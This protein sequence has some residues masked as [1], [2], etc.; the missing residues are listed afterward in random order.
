MKI[1]EINNEGVPRERNILR[2]TLAAELEIH[3]R[4][5][6]PVFISKQVATITPR[7]GTIILNFGSIKM[8]ITSKKVFLSN[9]EEKS[10]RDKFIPELCLAIQE[11]NTELFEFLVLEFSLNYKV[12]KS[13][14][15]FINT[16]RQVQQLLVKIQTDFT[17][18]NL[19]SLLQWKK[20]ISRFKINVEENEAAA[21]EV[22][23]NEAELA[24]LYLSLN[25]NTS[26]E[27]SNTEEAE[28]ILESFLEQI[29]D[30]SHKLSR[31][32]DD[33]D[34][35]QEIITLNLSNRRNSII[36]FDLFAT[37]LTGILAVLTLITG[38]FGMNI[39]NNVESSHEIFVWLVEGMIVL[40]VV[41]F[42]G[43]WLLFRKKKLI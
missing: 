20:K 39:K 6:R 40:F 8:I 15:K 41:L 28:S 35:T 34:D 18:K 5:L 27:D 32:E 33:I 38:I 1:I 4:D 26:E 3:L 30:V 42:V 21:L 16:E 43:A 2:K 25:H 13:K 11:N 37:V 24:D 14:T 19:A 23:E 9:L 22:M 12:K 29:E 31:L 36:Q 17:E 10:I 7:N